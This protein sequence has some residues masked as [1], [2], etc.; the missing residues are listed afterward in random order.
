MITYFEATK[1]FVVADGAVTVAVKV[2]KQVLGFFLRQV[3]AVVD[4]TP[5]EVFNVELAVTVIV[6]RFKNASDTFNAT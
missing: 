3:E 1:E 2:L 4:E 5:A 6:H